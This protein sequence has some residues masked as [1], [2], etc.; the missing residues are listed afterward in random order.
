MRT[1]IGVRLDT[2]FVR[3]GKMERCYLSDRQ[4]SA[5]KDYIDDHD[6]Y[7]LVSLGSLSVPTHCQRSEGII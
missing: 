7:E 3:N 4:M 1:N 6:T 5:V 2:T